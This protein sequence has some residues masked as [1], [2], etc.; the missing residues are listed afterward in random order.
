MA[1][2]NLPATVAFLAAGCLSYAYFE[3]LRLVGRRVVI[4]SALTRMAS[5]E[6][7][8]GQFVLGPVTLGLGAMVALMLY[9]EPAAAVA[10]YALAFGDSAASIFGK[11]FGRIRIPGTRGKTYF[12]TVA[13]FFAVLM[14]ASRLTGSVPAALVIAFAAAVF[15]ALPTGDLDNIVLPL[16]TGFVTAQ[17]LLAV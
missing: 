5:R 9:P 4:V 3:M 15:E 1:A 7:D 6:R 17:L 2:M 11:L 12:G 14:I 8:R 10:I 16:G 13:C